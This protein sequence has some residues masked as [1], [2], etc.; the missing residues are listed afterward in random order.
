[1]AGSE[2]GRLYLLSLADGK[3]IWSYELG[4]PVTA[5][6]AIADGWVVIGAEDGNVYAFSGP[7]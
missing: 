6:P 3:L 7:K 1:V 4:K 5:S 2:D